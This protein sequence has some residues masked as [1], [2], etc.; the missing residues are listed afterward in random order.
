MYSK[1]LL[2]L[3]LAGSLAASGYLL[4]APVAN[5]GSTGAFVGGMLTSRVLRNMSDRTKAE[6]QQ[7]YY[8][9]QEAQAAQAAQQQAQAPA[10]PPAGKTTQQKLDELDALAAGGYI[11]PEEYK[12]RREA[13]LNSM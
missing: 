13:I 6:Q 12:T 3:G 11:T 7:A 5:A 2:A 10:P 8:A 4:N 1:G 9:Q